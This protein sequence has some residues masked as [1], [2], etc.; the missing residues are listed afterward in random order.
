MQIHTPPYFINSQDVILPQQG[1]LIPWSLRK[2]NIAKLHEKGLTGSG[3]KVAIM[4]T[5]I[6]KSLLDFHIEQYRDFTGTGLEDRAGHGTHVAGTVAATYNK[7]Y[8]IGVSPGV[9]LYI[10]KV[11]DNG[12]GS[13]SFLVDAL[14][15]AIADGVDVINMSLG[16]AADVP[17][18]KD[19]CRRAYEAGIIIVAAAGNTGKV[20]NFYPASYDKYCLAVGAT[21]D[22]NQ[23]TDFSTKGHQ[24]DVSA[25]GSKI[26]S[27]FPLKMSEGR[28]LA[29][30]SGTSM[31][32]PFTTGVFCLI[33]EYVT[34]ILGTPKSLSEKIARRDRVYS[35]ILETCLDIED[36]GY[37]IE[38]GRGI[39]DAVPAYKYA[40]AWSKTINEDEE[41]KS[42]QLLVA[43]LHTKESDGKVTTKI[44]KVGNLDIEKQITIDENFEIFKEP[45][46]VNLS[47]FTTLKHLISN[48]LW[49]SSK[50]KS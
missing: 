34:K 25:P 24:I 28:G 37:D 14:D 5:G 40:Q 49:T 10:Y 23:V 32:A 50:D 21:T 35:L 19:A 41:V 43:Y 39:V 20:Q 47:Q 29:V 44:H 42:N 31:A 16:L 9:S 22:N 8:T 48:I 7:K 30:L 46:K 33:L 45:K 15:Q 27:T 1:E 36:S 38:S 12:S 4:D 6:D 17:A 11:M 2:F 3:I 13:I 26:L 18:L